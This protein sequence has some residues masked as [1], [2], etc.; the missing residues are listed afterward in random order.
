M[1]Y[2]RDDSHLPYLVLAV[3]HLPIKPLLRIK[4]ICRHRRPSANQRLPG[5]KK[6]NVANAATAVRQPC[7]RQVNKRFARAFA[8]GLLLVLSVVAAAPEASMAF[9]PGVVNS[10][11]GRVKCLR[12]RN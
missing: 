12:I 3:L 4:R 5:S 2:L 9:G 1:S 11:D 8:F 6:E 7:R 10:N